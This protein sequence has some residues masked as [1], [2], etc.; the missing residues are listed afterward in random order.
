VLAP[1]CVFATLLGS[2]AFFWHAR[3]WNVASRLMLTYA[4]VDR[5][6]VTIDGLED[7]THDRARV[8]RR[9]Y[10]E[11]PP[12]FSLL[13]APPYALA[14]WALGITGH[15]LGARG[16]THWPPDYWV[17]LATSGLFTAWAGALLTVLAGD[18][19]C[20]P[21]RATLVG[22]AYGLATPAYVY[23]TLST[24]AQ[25]EAAL[26][27]TAFALLWREAGTRHRRRAGLAGFLAAW[28]ATI[29]LQV[30][31]VSA[32]LGL[33]L[34]ARW[35]GGRARAGDVA[36]FGAGAL[37]PTAVLLLYNTAA[38]GSPFDSGYFHL[39]TRTFLAIHSEKNPF[40]LTLL[41][42]TE[43]LRRAWDL[44]LSRRR[45]LLFFAPVLWL[46]PLGWVPLA[47]RG[48]WGVLS[49]S[50][51]ACVAVFLVN[52]CYP[53]WEGGWSTGPRL[54]VPL[55]PFAMLPVA[56]SLAAAGNGTEQGDRRP[57]RPLNALATA[58]AVVLAL[59][60]GVIM[61]PCQGVGGRISQDFADPVFG[62]AWPLWRGDPV[63]AL[64]G[65]WPGLRFDRNLVNWFWPKMI[66]ELG[67]RR[68]WLQFVPLV[69]AQG[70]ALVATFWLCRPNEP[71]D[72]SSAAASS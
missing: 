15:P 18:L 49:V 57:T 33:D 44:L 27:L 13:A 46:A 50:L 55:L 60:G 35:A 61:L 68:A 12:G 39:E 32:V 9:Y 11:K 58:A 43:A 62:V 19:G 64:G 8:E 31:L 63:R 41:G 5:G 42:R 20:G 30:G 4:L 14:K 52:L 67:P 7:Q 10:S 28:A 21:R 71:S 53:A 3:D 16:F 29:D 25:V 54:L 66:W 47:R 23:A 70:L 72:R 37:V 69:A 6:T 36:A 22:L 40:G 45:G 56:A 48:W 17:T 24:G 51:A 2:Y 1:W 59:A 34:L 38:F 26:L 65:G